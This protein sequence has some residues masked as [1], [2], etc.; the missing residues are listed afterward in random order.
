VDVQSAKRQMTIDNEVIRS[1]PNTRNYN[2][3]VALVPGSSTRP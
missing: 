2:S 3:M 1:I